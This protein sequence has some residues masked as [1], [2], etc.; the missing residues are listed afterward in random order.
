LQAHAAPQ[1]LIAEQIE[2]EFASPRK[3]AAA[4]QKKARKEQPGSPLLDALKKWRLAEAKKHGLP[5]FRVL[6]DK[7]LYAVAEDLP[8]DDEDLLAISGISERIVKQYGKALLALV[9]EHI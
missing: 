1:F 3:K 7:A 8:S 5:A 6:T 9:E 4:K 2:A